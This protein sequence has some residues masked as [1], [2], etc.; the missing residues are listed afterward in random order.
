[1]KIFISHS[2]KDKNFGNSLVEL[3][4]SLGVKENEITFTS[5]TAYGIP[6]GQNIFKWL[7]SQITENP[8]VIYLLSEEYYRSVACLNEMGAAWIIE[9]EHAAIFTPNFDLSSKEFQGGALDPREIGFYINDEERILA[10]I[11]HLSTK[12]EITKN[13]IL[14]SQNVKK[15]L[16]QIK[17][18]KQDKVIQNQTFFNT[19]SIILSNS[20]VEDNITTNTKQVEKNDGSS[21]KNLYI[22]LINLVLDNKLKNEEVLLLH[23]IIETG[24]FKLMTGWQESQEIFNIKE[25][26][27]LNNIKNLLSQNYPSVIKRFELRGFTEVSAITSSA[28]PKEI[29]FKDEIT[30]EMLDLPPVVINKINDVVNNN[31]HEYIEE[32]ERYTDE[33]PW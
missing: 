30:L 27:K 22:K 8:F 11:H 28:N 31:Y 19:E 25:W 18:F 2:S 10:F 20:L 26:E 33:L 24:R 13:P 21:T 3:L 9:N 23:Y 12:F 16:E 14:I 15:F 6:I 5:N 7:K 29:K 32:E 1:M 4:R 17:N